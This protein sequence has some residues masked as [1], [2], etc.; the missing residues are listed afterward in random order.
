M[1]ISGAEASRQVLQSACP[2]KD[3]AD[4]ER[5]KKACQ[6]FESILIYKMLSTMRKA[7]ESEESDTGLGGDI[8]TS[9]MDEQLSTALA[10]GGGMGLADLLGKGLGL[11]K[12]AVQELIRLPQAPIRLIRRSITGTQSAARAGQL[13]GMTTRLAPYEAT[14]RAAAKAF[15]LSANLIR[16]V[17]MQESAGNPEAV[18]NKGAKGLMQLADATAREL[19]VTDPFDPI[20]NIFGGSRLLARLLRDFDGDLDLALASYNA[21]IGAVR[22]YGGIPP[23]KETRQYIEKVTRNLKMFGSIGEQA[24]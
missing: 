21:G 13:D 24:R 18:S 4:A 12:E 9:M 7:F 17:I 2:S 11:G 3:T 22:R 23:F 19:G 1:K 15:N 14:I 16:A 6:E 8:F 5:A 10:R 20:Q